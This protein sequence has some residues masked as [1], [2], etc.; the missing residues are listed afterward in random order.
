MTKEELEAALRQVLGGVKDADGRGVIVDHLFEYANVMEVVQKIPTAL[1]LK[2][3]VCTRFIFDY[4]RTRTR[5][6]RDHCAT[7]INR[8]ATGIKI[9]YGLYEFYE[10]FLLCK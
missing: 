1:R 8:S 3:F 6:V 5:S 7:W 2:Y 4:L 9:D 10:L